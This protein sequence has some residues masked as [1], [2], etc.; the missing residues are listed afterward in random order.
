VLLV[1]SL[2]NR[3]YI[4][5]LLPERSF[6]RHLAASGLR[7][8]LLDWGAPG[9]AERDFTLSDYILGPLSGALSAAV[10]AA[11]RSVA[12]LGYCMGGLLGLALALRRPADTAC[13]ALLATPW[14]FHAARPEQARLLALAIDSL[15]GTTASA[16]PLPIDALQAM[17]AAVDPFLAE[18]KFVRF[19]G[20]DPAGRVARDFVALEDWINDG[21]P[22][23]RKVALECARSW[24]RDNDPPNGRWQ[25]AARAVRPEELGVPTLVALPSRDRIVPSRSAGALAEAIPDA[26]VLRPASGHIGMMASTAAPETVWHPIAD[27]LR[28][29]LA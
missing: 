7:P 23:A 15:A 3:H 26:A 5:D 29:T 21:V 1:P 4:L 10:A 16:E 28:Q 24:Y 12:I 17:F 13:L 19:A 18:R 11:G 22:L 27:W 9:R 8:L 2:I 14:D 6:A 25:V 20:L